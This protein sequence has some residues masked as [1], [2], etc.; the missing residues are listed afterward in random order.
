[1]THRI[2]VDIGGKYETVY[3]YVE[4]D[5]EYNFELSYNKKLYSETECLAIEYHI[6]RHYEDIRHELIQKVKPKF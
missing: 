1:M 4:W 2:T 6:D 5:N 3:L